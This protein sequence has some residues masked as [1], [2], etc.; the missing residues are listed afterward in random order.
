[1]REVIGSTVLYIC[2]G[3]TTK[4]VLA[5]I[6]FLMAAKLISNLVDEQQ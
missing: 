6:M 3:C 5:L 1:M 4:L 2:L